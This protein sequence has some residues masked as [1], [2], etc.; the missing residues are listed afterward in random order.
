MGKKKKRG[1]IYIFLLS[2]ALI[3]SFATI[4]SIAK[5]NRSISIDY[6]EVVIDYGDTIWNIAREYTSE[7]KDIWL[8]IFEIKKI[9]NLSSYDIF[10][11]QILKIP[12]Y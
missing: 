6:C 12:I 4:F 10:P 11:G 8:T 1:K 5:A 2:F 9:N 7:D 3:I